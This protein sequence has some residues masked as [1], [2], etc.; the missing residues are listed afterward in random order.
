MKDKLLES[1]FIVQQ[2]VEKYKPYAVVMMLSGGTDS[3]AAMAA[4]MYLEI[5][6]NFVVHGNTRTGI[7]QTTEFVRNH[8]DELSLPYIEADAGNAFEERVREKGFFGKGRQAHTFAYHILKATPFRTA[9]SKNIRKGKH[10][11]NIL[12]LNGARKDES[13]NRS[14]NM[15]SPLREDPA[16]T[17]N[18]WVNIIH[19][20]TKEDCFAI[21]DTVGYQEN[22]VTK[23][24]CR[25][26]E[27]L[28]GTMQRKETRQ[29]AAYWYPDWGEWID[30]LSDSVIKDFP[31]DWGDPVPQSWGMEKKG[32]LNLFQPMCTGCLIEENVV[33]DD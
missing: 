17:R 27:C 32:Q 12:L 4:A 28:C 30:G 3:M 25:S 7:A 5:D 11:R 6:I 15:T 22:P 18:I 19:H 33:A 14:A 26:G 23:K 20:W 13:S 21:L 2:A 9:I 10:G 31:W 1:L 29:E 16:Q 24:L 8:V